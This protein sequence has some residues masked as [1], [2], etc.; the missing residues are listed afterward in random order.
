M[1]Q[2]TFKAIHTVTIDRISP[3]ANGK[4]LFRLGALVVGSS[5]SVDRRVIHAFN[6][7]A[8]DDGLPLDATSQISAA[9]LLGNV[10]GVVGAAYSML[11]ER[12]TRADYE[13]L[14][15]TWN[16]YKTGSAWTT[17]GGDVASDPAPIFTPFPSS[18]GDIVVCST[19]AAMAIDALANRGA[20][21]LLRWSIFPPAPSQS[22]HVTIKAAPTPDSDIARLRVT[23][24]TLV[25]ATEDRPA[26]HASRSGA[27]V[28]SPTGAASAASVGR[29]SQPARAT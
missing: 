4:D 11:T 8:P 5:K 28:A 13:Y 7:H 18:T 14:T 6:L 24:T 2:T 20:A 29:A 27:A 23:Y 16:E 1:P 19:L 12:L 25:P 10:T 3:T 22:E 21:L 9:E 17:P 26:H 15:A